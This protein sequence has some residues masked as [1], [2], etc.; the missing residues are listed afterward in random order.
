MCYLCLREDVFAGKG[1]TEEQRLRERAAH[2]KLL[3][4]EAESRRDRMCYIGDA[5]VELLKKEQYEL[6]KK[7]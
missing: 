2:V 1:Q 7:L 4:A 3:I 5:A 6:A